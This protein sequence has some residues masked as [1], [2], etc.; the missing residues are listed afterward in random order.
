M[1]RN[2]HL[3]RPEAL[4]AQRYRLAGDLNIVFTRVQLGWTLVTFAV[5]LVV[6]V[7]AIDWSYRK[8]VCPAGAV[9][10]KGCRFVASRPIAA[11]LTSLFALS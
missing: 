9:A 5:A 4:K 11:A 2:A 10:P 7:G 6:L 1:I 8:P 3:F